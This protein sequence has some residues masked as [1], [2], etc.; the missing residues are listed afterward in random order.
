MITS[1]EVIMIA[2]MGGSIRSGD[3]TLMSSRSIK[4]LRYRPV[5]RLANYIR[6]VAIKDGFPDEEES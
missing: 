1:Q 4:I 6:G 3:D 5:N 2:N